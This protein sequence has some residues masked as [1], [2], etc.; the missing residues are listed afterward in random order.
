MQP[1]ERVNITDADIAQAVTNRE[2]MKVGSS[3]GPSSLG[4]ALSL[5]GQGDRDGGWQREGVAAI[6]KRSTQARA[7]SSAH[8][9]RTV[10]PHTPT[11]RPPPSALCPQP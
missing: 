9:P 2:A 1:V 10:G 7:L 11:V 5:I 3:A 6:R 8:T 4:A